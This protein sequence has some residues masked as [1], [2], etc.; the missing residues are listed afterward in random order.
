MNQIGAMTRFFFLFFLGDQQRTRRKAD[1]TKN[2]GPLERDFA[3]SRT[4]FYCSCGTASSYKKESV[5]IFIF[6]FVDPFFSEKVL[7]IFSGLYP[8]FE[9][10]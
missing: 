4:T 2:F 5:K 6:P 7:N 8:F 1:Q 9:G 10:L 3:L